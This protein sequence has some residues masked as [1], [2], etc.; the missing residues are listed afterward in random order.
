MIAPLELG[1]NLKWVNM[2]LGNDGLIRLVQR[3][4]KN[5]LWG[6]NPTI[7]CMKVLFLQPVMGKYL[8]FFFL[9]A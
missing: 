7:G 3:P 6:P 5:P 1:S 9:K 2:L 8:D 4:P